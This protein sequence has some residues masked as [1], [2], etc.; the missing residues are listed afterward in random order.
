[1]NLNQLKIFYLAAKCEN[2]SH[3][4]EELNITQPA[5]TKGIQR[6]Q[7]HYEIKLFNR[8]GKKLIMTDAGKDLYRIAEKIFD[9][10]AQA[11][12]SIRDF[13]EQKKGHIRIHA[14]ESFGAYYL[15]AI[16]NAFCKEHP[17]LRLSASILPTKTV[18]ENIAALKTDIGF[19]S[20][21][22]EHEK[23]TCIEILEDQMIF[24]ASS[25]DPLLNKKRLTVMDLNGRAMIVHEKG[26]VPSQIITRFI[27]E[28]KISV[29]IPLELSSNRAI[30]KAVSDGLGIALVCRNVAKEGFRSNRLAEL[31]FP[32]APITRKFY[33]VHHKDKYISTVLQ[34]LIDEVNIWSGDYQQ[35][36]AEKIH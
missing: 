22:I 2:L 4:A 30:L 6:I 27:K 1:M 18:V 8:F 19:T 25:N 28:N 15:P 9:L 13:Q 23:V 17:L 20:N 16:I 5:V 10:E 12:E 11:E 32:G 33:L 21:K 24:I 31:I 7:E 35:A 3:A 29:S 36:L 34:R 26:S 14:S